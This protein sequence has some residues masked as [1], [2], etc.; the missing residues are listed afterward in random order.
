VLKG[1][2]P[3]TTKEKSRLKKHKNKLRTLV[4]KKVSLS[5]KK[6]II[7]SGGGFLGAL[8]MPVASLLGSLLFR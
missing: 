6:D 4:K 5:K 2:V 1:N 8:L 7:Q 3:L